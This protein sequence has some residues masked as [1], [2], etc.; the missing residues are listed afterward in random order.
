MDSRTANEVCRE[1]WPQ[2]LRWLQHESDS[3]AE[4]LFKR[5]RDRHLDRF[6]NGQLRT[7]QRRVRQWRTDM[8][9]QLVYGCSD[10]AQPWQIAPIGADAV[11]GEHRLP[12][13]AY[14]LNE[15]ESWSALPDRQWRSDL[16]TPSPPLR[17]STRHA[18]P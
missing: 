4:A 13:A 5:L 11:P 10:G 6:H 16:S 2:V 3:T 12:G 7:L 8:V 9:R 1:V 18:A 15:A 14:P 17:R